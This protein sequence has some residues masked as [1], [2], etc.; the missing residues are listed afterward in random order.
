MTCTASATL[1]CIKLDD[2]VLP[3]T[4]ETNYT[5]GI[6]HRLPMST[7]GNLTTRLD[8]IRNDAQR[9]KIT[10]QIDMREDAYTVA[11]VSTTYNSADSQWALTF[12]IRNATDAV[13]S[14]AGSFSTATATRR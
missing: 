12:G 2:V 10:N 7:G 5:I 9:F 1:V 14:T 8:Y 13:Y 3:Y 6:T 4:P 11:N